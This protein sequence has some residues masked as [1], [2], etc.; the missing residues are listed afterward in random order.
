[1]SRVAC[2]ELLDA[3]NRNAF[4][5]RGQLFFDKWCFIIIQV[6]AIHPASA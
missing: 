2:V 5:W 1:M 6:Q 4:F 3:L